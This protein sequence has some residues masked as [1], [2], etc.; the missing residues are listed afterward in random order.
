MDPRESETELGATVSNTGLHLIFL[1]VMEA[2]CTCTN[3]RTC[4]GTLKVHIVLA[5][6]WINHE[7]ANQITVLN[8][9]SGCGP[10]WA[11]RAGRGGE[12]WYWWWVL[13]VTGP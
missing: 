7:S 12:W 3:V 13:M 9:H 10:G 5:N 8:P 2:L 4:I 6:V 11:V 1:W